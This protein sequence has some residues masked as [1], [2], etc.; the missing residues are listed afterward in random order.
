M[1]FSHQ[2]IKFSLIHYTHT[3]P[4]G[5]NAIG[6]GTIKE[7]DTVPFEMAEEAIGGKL[8]PSGGGD[9]KGGV[10]IAKKADP[11]APGSPSTT[12]PMGDG[13]MSQKRE[14]GEVRGAKS[15]P[16]NPLADRQQAGNDRDRNR[17]ALPS[18]P[19]E[20]TLSVIS[21]KS[22]FNN[23]QPVVPIAPVSLNPIEN[24]VEKVTS[25]IGNFDSQIKAKAQKALAKLDPKYKEKEAAAAAA[26]AAER[27]KHE[28]AA[29][30]KYE[31]EQRVAK[32]KWEADLKRAKDTARQKAEQ[33]AELRALTKLDS[34]IK[35]QEDIEAAEAANR[36]AAEVDEIVS[37]AIA[38]RMKNK[39]MDP[40]SSP[41]A[42]GDY[43]DPYGSS[44]GGYGSAGGGTDLYGST[45]RGL[46]RPG[47]GDYY[48]NPMGTGGYG[49]S[50]YGGAGAGAGVYGGSN[51]GSGAYGADKYGSGPYGA[52]A[53]QYGQQQGGPPVVGSTGC[54]CSVM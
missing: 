9:G 38:A 47:E 11:T 26:A 4:D 12:F 7:S 45:S 30:K 39:K 37:Q 19:S 13:N 32:E 34:L 16:L 3:L 46:G 31:E 24:A 44:A 14:G 52:G 28:D 29:R 43:R 1:T 25:A 5:I 49:R 18:R 48:D 40:Q 2:N 41:R 23:P 27:K 33:E 36:E 22:D 8:R 51:Y 10:A 54:G 42:G 15:A 35:E 21:R 6:K 53:G 17:G 50:Q 20:D